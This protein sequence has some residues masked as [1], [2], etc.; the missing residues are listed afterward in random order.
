MKLYRIGVQRVSDD[1]HVGYIYAG[2]QKEVATVKREVV[3]ADNKVQEI[4]A[5]NMVPTKAGL[6]AALN[7]YGSHPDNG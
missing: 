2:S 1:E 5:I 6:L 3:A 4:E 7:R